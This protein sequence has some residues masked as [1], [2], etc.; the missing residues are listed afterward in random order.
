M[1]LWWNAACTC[2]WKQTR[3]STVKFDKL[4]C[5]NRSRGQS[6]AVHLHLNNG[7]KQE[8]LPCMHSHWLCVPSVHVDRGRTHSQ[9][10]TQIQRL[11]AHTHGWYLGLQHYARNSILVSSPQGSVQPGVSKVQ[12]IPPLYMEW[13]VM[14][15][16]QPW[17]LSLPAKTIIFIVC[18]HAE[19]LR[20]WTCCC[21]DIVRPW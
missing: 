9:L 8:F 20:E 12:T 17:C 7:L 10:R 14:I 18:R 19:S 4:L 5:W 6:F 2:K 15:L 1:I 3:T 11:A 13:Q 16:P 21:A